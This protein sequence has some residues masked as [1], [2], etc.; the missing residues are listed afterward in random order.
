MEET[1]IN[2]P[3]YPECEER[4][5]NELSKCEAVPMYDK[6]EE[7]YRRNINVGNVGNNINTDNINLGNNTGKKPQYD[8]GENDWTEKNLNTIIKWRDD[9]AK[10]SFIYGQL[11]D[12][13]EFYLQMI[14][15]L[16]LILG[17]LITILAGV[18]VALSTL[19]VDSNFQ[20]VIFWF[21]I[22]MLCSSGTIIT[23]NGIVKIFS[24]DDKIKILT[25]IIEKLDT[26]WFIFETELN[27]P[28]NQRENAK[29]FIKRVDGDYMHL[30][31]ICPH[32]GINDYV[33]ANKRY[34]E[35]LSNNLIWQ[36]RFRKQVEEKLK[37]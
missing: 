4:S 34:Q 29:D 27:K 11:L 22:I 37:E 17:T 5:E 33:K 1:V 28:S 10:N 3:E 23:L 31:Q 36:H 2:I 7:N 21:N 30:M 16:T 19:D 6:Y 8:K 20:W 25:K 15:V 26:Q 24:L 32:V 14:L 12:T 35:S 13:K 18:S 9:I